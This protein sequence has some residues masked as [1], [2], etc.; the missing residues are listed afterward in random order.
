VND[1]QINRAAELL[2]CGPIKRENPGEQQVE[3]FGVLTA[4]RMFLGVRLNA[5]QYWGDNIP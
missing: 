1:S 3:A 2:Q 4:S 5:P